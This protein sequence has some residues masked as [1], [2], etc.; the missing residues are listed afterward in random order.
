MAVAKKK[1]P[2]RVG[3]MV[4][5]RAAVYP[6]KAVKLIKKPPGYVKSP[7]STL[8]VPEGGVVDPSKLRKGLTKAKAEIN[9]LIQEVIDTATTDYSIHE[10]EFAAGFSADGKFMGIGVGGAASIT[11]RIRPSS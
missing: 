11:F 8:L 10:I 4:L 2:K 9:D 5:K 3:K 1:A 6:V 7:T